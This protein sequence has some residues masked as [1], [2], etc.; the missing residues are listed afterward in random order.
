MA[1]T[2][3]KWADF[4]NPEI[5]R[6]KLIS[7]GLFLMAHEMLIDTLKSHLLSF[8]ADRWDADGPETSADYRSEV[9][10]LDPKGKDDALRGSIAWF[11][12]MGAIDEVDEAAI[13]AV[14]DA[15]NRLAHEMTSMISGAQTSHHIECF[16]TLV[17]LVHKIEKWWII[18][19]EIETDPDFAGQGID[20]D[21]IVTGPSMMMQM[22]SQ[23]AL[24]DDDD[25]WWYLQEFIKQTNA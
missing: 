21:G 3:E 14:T 12:K 23:I 15:R 19:V 8:F 1:D 6:G 2:R 10:A 7:A 18:N 22:L 11:R 24:G 20:E 5:V 25:A 4:L 9:L 17:G 13:K 16:P